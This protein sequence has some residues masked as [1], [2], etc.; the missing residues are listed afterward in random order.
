MAL[1]TTRTA[2]DIPV[3]GLAHN[4]ARACG[5]RPSDPDDLAHALE[6]AQTVLGLLVGHLRG[7]VPLPLPVDLQAVVQGASVR[8]ALML[9]QARG[10]KPVGEQEQ[11]PMPS[12]QGWTFPEVVVLARYRQRTT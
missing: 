9:A 10:V 8:Y 1:T 6:A 7:R 5:M 4:V 2:E 3:E 11:P 12:F